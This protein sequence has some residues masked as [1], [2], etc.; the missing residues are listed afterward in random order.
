MSMLVLLQDNDSSQ[1]IMLY[2]ALNA[3]SI[4]QGS[5]EVTEC[6]VNEEE[7][8]T[9]LGLISVVVTEKVLKRQGIQWVARMPSSFA[10]LSL[11]MD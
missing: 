9:K 3:K 2:R 7:K 10:A 8:R 5:R 6:L 1:T 11:A 4:L